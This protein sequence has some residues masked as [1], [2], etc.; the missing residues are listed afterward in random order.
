MAYTT[1]NMIVKHLD[2]L[3][4]DA[5]DVG[6]TT[7]PYRFT[8]TTERE[9]FFIEQSAFPVIR[10]LVQRTAQSEVTLAE[11]TL[12]NLAIVYSLPASNLVSDTLTIDAA[13]RGTI[14]MTATGATGSAPAGKT[15]TFSMPQSVVSG[16]VTLNLARREMS[17]MP[18][19]IAHLA[20]STGSI[21]TISDA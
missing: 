8:V 1:A 21:G 18:I 17:V 3:Q 4:L 13:D 16:D 10:Q 12:A 15:R 2:Q 20:D 5:V 14:A 6:G 19:T 11:P 7:E 9:D